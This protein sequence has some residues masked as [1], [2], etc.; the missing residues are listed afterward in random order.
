M[1]SGDVNV[2]GDQSHAS[3][4]ACELKYANGAVVNTSFGHASHEA[5]ELKFMIRKCTECGKE[6]HASH[7]ACELKFVTYFRGC[8]DA[9]SRLA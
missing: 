8:I 4:E 3:H 1:L 2:L 5:C 7:E 9:A 6:C